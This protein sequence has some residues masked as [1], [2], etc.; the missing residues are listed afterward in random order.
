MK[1]E[2]FKLI[3]L[4][5]ELNLAV[6]KYLINFPNKEIELKRRIKDSAYELLLITYE[7]NV[8]MNVEKK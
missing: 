2:K 8:T 3:E 7:A 5:K 1:V 6:D 4:I